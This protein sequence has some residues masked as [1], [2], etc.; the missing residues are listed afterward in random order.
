MFFQTR[1]PAMLTTASALPGRDTPILAAAPHHVN[2]HPIA[3]PYPAGFAIA[4]FALG[5]FWGAE[6]GYWQMPGVW[7]TAVGYQG[8][9]TPNATYLEA[10][11]GKTGLRRGGSR[12]L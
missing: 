10:C 5:C 12:R 1:S 8:G 3:G 7:V 9:F 11:P 6:K 4:E 2:G